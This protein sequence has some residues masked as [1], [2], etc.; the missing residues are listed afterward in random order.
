MQPIIT[1]NKCKESDSPKRPIHAQLLLAVWGESYIQDFFNLSLPSLLAVGNIPAFSQ[2]IPTKFVF[3][4]RSADIP[5]FDHYPAFTQLKKFCDVEFV[6]ID[7]LLL[8]EFYSISLTLAY[9]RAIKR[10]AEKMLDTYFVFL[11]ADFIF[12]D[13]SLL[14]LLRYIKQGYSGICT[15]NFQVLQNEMSAYLANLADPATGAISLSPRTL[16]AESFKYLHP[17]TLVNT[18]F[19]C[20]R[21]TLKSDYRSL[22]AW[23][24]NHAKH[25]Y[26]ANRFFVRY[27]NTTLAGRYFLQ[28]MFCIRPEVQ[29]YTIA[30]SCDY[31]FIPAMCPSGKIGFINDSDDFL[32]VEVQ[33][34]E[35]ELSY[36]NNGA[37]QLPKLAR[38]LAGWTTKLHRQNAE[39]TIYFHTENITATEKQALDAQ[40]GS[41]VEA[42][43]ERLTKYPP[44]PI[45]NP[46]WAQT[47][48]IFNY[49]LTAIQDQPSYLFH[50][51]TPTSFSSFLKRW[52]Y[53][54]LG[55]PPLVS[56]FHSRYREHQSK[57]RE[58]AHLI[59]Q[60]KPEN[61]IIL[62]NDY[63]ALFMSYS[64]WLR[65]T[66]G[67][68][69]QYYLPNLLLAP[70]Q[71]AK[72]DNQF[73]LVIVFSKNHHSVDKR[74][75]E[76]FLNKSTQEN[77]KQ[78]AFN[79]DESLGDMMIKK[80]DRLFDYNKKLRFFAYIIIGVPGGIAYWIYNVL[81]YPHFRD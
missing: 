29:H 15:G 1:S 54:V 80:I 71:L 5:Q 21:N 3:L 58:L 52:Y 14:G 77:I 64:G 42:I 37:Y 20:D 45:E 73:N 22:I 33:P 62:F 18:V 4:T 78:V 6:V 66:L 76:R 53:R 31:S 43:N 41:F 60:A 23:Q 27:G 36:I 40:L 35:H 51:L 24:A 74:R 56:R 2:A 79:T 65:K 55:M 30:E 26:R 81:F 19:A 69:H 72:R 57:M 47:A 70:D 34:R 32:V 49:Q 9:D 68:R 8:I 46:K 10:S 38:S 13:G 50:D 28:H 16:L 67:V 17:I 63:Q 44:R 25:N 12:A 48:A 7:D 59:Q 61:T 75:V 11:T 39:Q